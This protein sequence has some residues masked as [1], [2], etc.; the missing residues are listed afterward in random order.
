MM[1][2]FA[3]HPVGFTPPDGYHAM[4]PSVARRGDEIVLA[5]RCVNYVLTDGQYE[6]PDGAPIHTRNFLLRLDDALEV[7]SSA[8]IL[9]P[10]DM[11]AASYELVKGFEDIRLFAWRGELWCCRDGA[12][13]DTGGLVR[14]ALGAPRRTRP[15]GVPACRLARCCIRRVRGCTR[16]TG[17][18]SSHEDSLRSSISATRPGSSTSRR[19]RSPRA[20]RRS[21][22]SSSA[23][24]RRRSPLTMAGSRLMHEAR[25]RSGSAQ[26]YYQHR[27]VWLDEANVLRRVSR[28][29]FFPQERGR[30]CRGARLASRR[31]A[32]AGLL[33]RR[34]SR[35]LARDGRRRR[36]PRGAGRRSAIAL[37]TAGRATAD[38]RRTRRAGR[39]RRRRP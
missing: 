13:A 33:R 4:N 15:R 16:R 31:R 7:Q 34:R 37:R 8:E 14:A 20:C 26:R 19:A 17:C 6:T 10:A 25:A 11:P 39:G 21:P 24:A 18:R 2:S 36:G 38:G 3:A 23:A 29:F 32:P 12:R 5:Q 22:P 30:V 35:K 1:P 9:P 28:A 27:F